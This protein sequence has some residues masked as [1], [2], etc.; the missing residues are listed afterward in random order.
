MINKR[1]ARTLTIAKLVNFQK[2]GLKKADAEVSCTKMQ[3]LRMS[4]GDTEAIKEMTISGDET[5]MD[6]LMAYVSTFTT[7][8]T[9]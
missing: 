2:K 7:G 3:F 1:K 8:F 4:L 5:V 6:R 9:P